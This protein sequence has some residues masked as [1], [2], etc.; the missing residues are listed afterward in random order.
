M[1]MPEPV[2]VAEGFDIAMNNHDLQAALDSFTDD[3]AIRIEPPPP[4]P[5]REFYDGKQQ[6]RDWLQQLMADNFHAA[7]RNFEIYDNTVRWV[8]DIH[9]GRFEELGVDPIETINEAAVRERRISSLT[10]TFA[11]EDMDALQR[12][13]AARGVA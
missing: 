13:T 6:I 5:L 1:E 3:A 8:W 4:A 12:A 10:I 7:W 2:S 9:T 11:P